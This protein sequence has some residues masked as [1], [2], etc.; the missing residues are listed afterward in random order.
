MTLP[1]SLMDATTPPMLAPAKPKC[2]RHDWATVPWGD[3]SSGVLSIGERTICRRCFAVRDETR[4]KRGRN[5]G[6]RGRGDELRVAEI[7][8]GRKVGPLGLPWDVELA[9]YLR[10]QAKQLDRWPSLNEVV[11]WLDA[12]PAGPELRGVTLANTPGPGRRTRRLVVFDL[13]EFATWHGRTK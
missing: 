9:D 5:N 2:R 8:G 7:V 3:T 1:D 13:T 12:I 4:A 11:K 10:L 6:K